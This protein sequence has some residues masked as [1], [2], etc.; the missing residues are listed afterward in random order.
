MSDEEKKIHINSGDKALI[1]AAQGVGPAVQLTPELLE[2]IRQNLDERTKEIEEVYPKL[3]AECPYDTKLAIVAWVFEH[4]V[5][6]AKEGGTFRYLIYD[7]LG[8]GLDAYV[9]LYYAGGMTIS[10]E[11]TLGDTN[12]PRHPQNQAS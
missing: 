8:F 11:F 5:A 6:H 12:G 9:P 2:D 7:R 4:I 3:V 1:D 10:N